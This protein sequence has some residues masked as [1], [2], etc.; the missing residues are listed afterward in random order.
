L[1]QRK[2]VPIDAVLGRQQPAS[3]PLLDGVDRIAR[4]RLHDES[5]IGMGVPRDHHAERAAS[6]ELRAE[7]VGG[8]SIT[9]RRFGLH[10]R[11]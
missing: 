1:R 6:I 7:C 9:D 10:H 3:E 11:D 5:E 4:R 2:L 8:D